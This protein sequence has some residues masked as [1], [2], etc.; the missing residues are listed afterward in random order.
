MR[1]EPGCLTAIASAWGGTTLKYVSDIILPALPRRVTW[2]VFTLLRLVQA[3]QADRQT[4][5]FIGLCLGLFLG[6][7]VGLSVGL[8]LGLFVGLFVGLSV[9]LFLG[10]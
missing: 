5:G 3:R 6:L 2:A 1:I 9:G 10:L 7:F 8:F 4:G